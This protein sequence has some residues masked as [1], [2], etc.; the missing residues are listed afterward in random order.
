[1]KKGIIL[2]FLLVAALAVGQ[3]D[4][5]GPATNYEWTDD[6][7]PGS[8]DGY[9]FYCSSESPVLQIPE[10]EI[11]FIPYVDGD[12]TWTM[13]F[14]QGTWFCAVSCRAP[15]SESG[16][17]NEVTFAVNVAPHDLQRQAALIE[18]NE[19]LVTFRMKAAE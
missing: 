11:T 19:K 9:P 7:P 13:S 3:I 4:L 10:N 18:A 1:M 15:L 6:N 16:L 17:S 8:V 14:T 5:V 12:E 2:V